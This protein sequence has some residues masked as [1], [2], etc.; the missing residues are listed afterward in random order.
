[1]LAHSLNTP[2][3]T[4][5]GAL[6]KSAPLDTL[7][8]AQE[9]HNSKAHQLDAPP[10]PSTLAA[11]SRRSRSAH[12]LRSMVDAETAAT[13]KR[14]SS[15]RN[16]LRRLSSADLAMLELDLGSPDVLGSGSGSPATP[17]LQQPP[18]L[19][20]SP[21]LRSKT[22]AGVLGTWP[23]PRAKSAHTPAHASLAGPFL[24][25]AGDAAHHDA[26][27]DHLM[28]ARSRSSF[29]TGVR[30]RP[31][32]ASTWTRRTKKKGSSQ[33]G[34]RTDSATF[35]PFVDGISIRLSLDLD[36]GLDDSDSDD[37]NAEDEGVGR[38]YVPVRVTQRRLGFFAREPFSLAEKMSRYFDSLRKPS[39]SSCGSDG[40]VDSQTW[41]SSLGLAGD[42]DGEDTAPSAEATSDR[43]QPDAAKPATGA[44]VVRQ[45]SGAVIF[46]V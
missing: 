16:I 11:Q 44:V 32:S 2:E 15:A 35:D 7:L 9:H 37:D 28:L 19:P 3:G 12:R 45:T 46:L 8:A 25:V 42:G 33:G 36:L 22:P 29:T 21:L 14:R 39:V 20:H 24:T 4:T 41:G 26:F 18:P 1:M 6:Q 27:S 31:H 5:N 30:R 40:D 13:R 34:R 23:V 10:P 17:L 38:G 43:G